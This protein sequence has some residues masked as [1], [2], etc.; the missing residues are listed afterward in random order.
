MIL[1]VM[2]FV[3]PSKLISNIKESALYPILKRLE[4]NDFLTTYSRDIREESR[5]YYSLT[6]LGH[7][8]LVRLKDA[9]GIHILTR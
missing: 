9:I 1:M 6:Q 5:K 8:E 7:E 4:Q 2:K 3:R